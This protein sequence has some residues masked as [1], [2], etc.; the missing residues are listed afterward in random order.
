M[1]RVLVVDD[2][3]LVRKGL[4]SAMPWSDFGMEVVGEASNGEKALEFLELQPVELLLTDLAMP[5]MSGLELMRA[6]R[7]RYPE[8]H[9]VVLTFHQDFEYVQEALRLGAIDYIAKVQL[10][11]EHFDEVLQ[12]VTAQIHERGQSVHAHTH[13]HLHPPKGGRSEKLPDS[14][15]AFLSLGRG[16]DPYDNP[17]PSGAVTSGALVEVDRHLWLWLPSDSTG[18]EKEAPEALRSLFTPSLGWGMLELQGIGSME[19]KDLHGSLLAYREG[20]FFY[21]FIPT[22]GSHIFNPAEEKA[23]AAEDREPRIARLKSCWASREWIHDDAAYQKVKNELKDLRLPKAKLLGLLYALLDD[24]NRI[25]EQLGFHRVELQEVP[26]HWGRVQAEL[27]AIRYSIR[28]S[29]ENTSFSREVVGAVMKAVALVHDELDRPVTAADVAKRVGMSRS[30]FSQCFRDIIGST[31]NDY[32]RHVRMERAKE[33]LLCTN[34]TIAWIAENTGYTDEKY[35]SRT[36]RD[37]E[38][39]LPSEFRSSSLQR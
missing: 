30:Y 24:W 37:Y 23:E 28:R 29:I 18:P 25:G 34:K 4:I 27:D 31:F 9:I 36:F 11:K 2:D 20:G 12:R 1:I 15:A 39:L 21:D 7:K 35:F 33:L 16:W 8:I 22:G 14:G 3:K 32:L 5:V 19:A 10:E 13:A 26:H 6:V 17:L 38:G